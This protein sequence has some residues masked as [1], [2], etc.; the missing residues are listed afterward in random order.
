MKEREQRAF[1]ARVVT[2]RTYQDNAPHS[3]LYHLREQ[4]R[5]PFV[6]SFEG[7]ILI[8]P[9]EVLGEGEVPLTRESAQEAARQSG[10]V[11]F[12][13]LEQ[14]GDLYFDYYGF[15]KALRLLS[16]PKNLTGDGS[17]SKLLERVQAGTAFAQLD[18]NLGCL[19]NVRVDED[20][21]VFGDIE[22]P[23]G[24]G[25]PYLS[26]G[27]LRFS[28][29]FGIYNLDLDETELSA[30]IHLSGIAL[31]EM[32]VFLDALNPYLTKNAMRL[33][34]RTRHANDGSATFALHYRTPWVALDGKYHTSSLVSGLERYRIGGE[35]CS[36]YS[37][38]E[39]L[40]SLPEMLPRFLEVHEKITLAK[41]KVCREK[42]QRETKAVQGMRDLIGI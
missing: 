15:V 20:G 12:N 1:P 2:E 22:K 31:D 13:C 23:Q 21:G 6:V 4:G 8:P 19:K 3:F 30:E 26:V 40:K 16:I 42:K 27:A 35:G 24:N 38:G 34:P 41:E 9:N 32:P 29:D 25:G 18:A 39:G 36:H 33:Y 7:D 11:A 5:L 37:L 10:G 17:S 14:A 28:P